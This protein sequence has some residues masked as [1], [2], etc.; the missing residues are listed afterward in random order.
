MVDISVP[1]NSVYV[2]AANAPAAVLA[3]G[4]V[5]VERY[6]GKAAFY[7]A[8]AIAKF[9]EPQIVLGDAIREITGV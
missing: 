4:P 9:I 1:D 5:W 8:Y 3:T 7:D 6:S 2:V